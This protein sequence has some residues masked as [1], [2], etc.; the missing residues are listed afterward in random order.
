MDTQILTLY[1]QLPPLPAMELVSDLQRPPRPRIR[2][3]WRM[4]VGPVHTRSRVGIA[5]PGTQ[6][7]AA[8]AGVRL[9]SPSSEGQALF[10]A[11]NQPSFCSSQGSPTLVERA[12]VINTSPALIP[13][14][15]ALIILQL[16]FVPLIAAWLRIPVYHFAFSLSPP[17]C[18]RSYCILYSIWFSQ[19]VF[20][21]PTSSW[22][23][24]SFAE[25]CF[26][27]L[28]PA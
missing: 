25:C 8:W 22:K 9:V 15:T 23:Q 1:C 10:L 12:H 4:K 3:W 21:I 24:H 2:I 6:P 28:S 20:G 19:G 7:P 16:T 27:L 14:L 13:S 11:G 18:S 5:E 17:F 26:K